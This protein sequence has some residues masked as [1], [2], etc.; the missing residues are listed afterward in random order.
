M[1]IIETGMAWWVG[2]KLF[3]MDCKTVVELEAEDPN[4]SSHW[5][6]VDADGSK[7][8]VQCPTCR[9]MLKL[10][11]DQCEDDIALTDVNLTEKGKALVKAGGV[12]GLKDFL[13]A[14]QQEIL[15]AKVVEFWDDGDLPKVL[16]GEAEP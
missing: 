6:G 5:V 11:Q 14:F 15:N 7:V 16:K 1:K 4:T 8:S 12:P 2:K 13:P 10:T 9:R 3:C